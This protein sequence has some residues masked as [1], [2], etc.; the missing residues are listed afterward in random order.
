MHILCCFFKV[1]QRAIWA[2][3]FLHVKNILRAPFLPRAPPFYTAHA[4]LNTLILYLLLIIGIHAVTSVDL[5]MRVH[6]LAPT[7]VRVSVKH[8]PWTHGPKYYWTGFW[9]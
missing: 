3:I 5:R 8:E 7:N 2:A 4:R 9:T 1:V 6:E